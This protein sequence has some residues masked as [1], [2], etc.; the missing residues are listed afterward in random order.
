MPGDSRLFDDEAMDIVGWESMYGSGERGQEDHPTAL[1]VETAPKL[2]AGVAIDLA[3]GT[4]RNALYLAKHGWSVTAL[5]GSETAIAIAGKRASE[6]GLT[7][8]AE[9]ADLTASSFALPKERFDLVVIAYYWQPDLFPVAK[10]SVRSGGAILTIAHTASPGEEASKKRAEP[11][12][13]LR[14]F[15]GWEI[16]HHYEGPSRDP[17]H[18]KPVAEIVARRPGEAN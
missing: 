17:A 5:D 15:S 1:L 3:C 4:G 10:A 9:V 6:R 13:L 16:L 18:R 14:I 2:S 7:L 12:Q 11:G 8:R